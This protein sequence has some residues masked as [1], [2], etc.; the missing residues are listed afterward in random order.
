M[1]RVRSGHERTADQWDDNQDQEPEF[2][3]DPRTDPSILLAPM[4]ERFGNVL[5][6]IEELVNIDSGSFTAEGVNRI[7]AL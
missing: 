6:R 4:R 7:A 3:T 5:D 1:T 2:V